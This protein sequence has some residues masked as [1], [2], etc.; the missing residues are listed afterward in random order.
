MNSAPKPATGPTAAANQAVLRELPF[1]DTSDFDD[2]RRGHIAPLP[3]GVVR[4]AGGKLVW[5][6]NDYAFLAR[7]EA[8]PEVN[9]SL[10]RMARLNMANGL[11]EVTSGVFQVRGID[12]AN[13]TIV[14]GERGIIVVDALTNAESAAAALALYRAHRGDRPVSALV[15]THSHSDHYG[16]ALGV[17]SLEEVRQGRVP[18]IAPDGFMEELGAEMVLAGIPMLRRSHFQFGGALVKGERGQVDAGLGKRT[19]A[20]TSTLLP[21]TDLIVRPVERR[22][23]DGVE[24]TFQ[25]AP[26]TEAPAEMHI[27][28][29]QHRLLNMAENTTR[30]LH[31]FIPLR[32]AQARDTRVWSD[33][34]ATSMELFGAEAEILVAQHHWPIWGNARLLAY[35]ARQ[36]DLYKHIHDQTLRLAA[37]GL[38]PAEIAERLRLPETLAQD[39]ACRSYYG[40]VSHNAKAVYQRYLSWYDGNPANLNPL[41]PVEA[42]RKL[43][44]YLGPLEAVMEHARADFGRGEYRWVAQLMSQLVFADAGN[45]AAR[46][47][48]ADAYEQLGYQAESAT[49]RNAYLLAAQELRSGIRPGRPIGFLRGDMLPALATAVVFDWLGVRL[50][51]EKAAGLAWKID[52][53]FTDRGEVVAQTLENAT[54]TQ[55]IGKPSTAPHASVTT[56]RAAFDRVV[57]GGAAFEDIVASG[58]A[59]VIGDSSLPGRLF[60]LLDVFQPM[61]PVVT[62]V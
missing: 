59:R 37:H 46:A 30:H 36:R 19:G 31:N 14:E 7:E 25:M 53:H 54:L 49:W 32:G 18:V 9:P 27:Y 8:P 1:H 24:M 3:E 38:R 13:M 10:W 4:G 60:T 42:G 47:L 41:P 28:F 45:E 57:A 56:T 34:I 17:A 15:Y 26:Q 50:D 12:L 44:E 39:W 22:I 48:L 29:P 61:F 16:G 21:P 6:L 43:M 2:A 20:G 40:T 52:W 11:F 33:A 62:P 55:R 35:L 58:E 23:V 51:A 5:D